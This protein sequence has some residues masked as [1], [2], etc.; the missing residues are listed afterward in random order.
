VVEFWRR[1]H[2]SLG[3][4]FRVN[5]YFPMGGSRKGNVRTVF[6]LLVV[7]LF[8][9]VWHGIGGNYLVWALFLVILIINERFWLG[10]LLKKS[11]VWC[12]IYTVFQIHQFLI[13]IPL[14]QQKATE[15]LN[16]ALVS[17]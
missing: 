12:H 8:T 3:A 10:K 17:Q 4:W 5:I 14:Y 13:A 6:N 11:N 2:A 15:F 16:Q 7:W 9:G 1:W